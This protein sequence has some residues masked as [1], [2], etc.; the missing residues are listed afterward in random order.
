MHQVISTQPVTLETSLAG[1]KLAG[2][3]IAAHALGFHVKAAF[4]KNEQREIELQTDDVITPA[5]LATIVL[6]GSLGERDLVGRLETLPRPHEIALCM[7]CA[8]ASGVKLDVA[9]DPRPR[10]WVFDRVEDARVILAGKMPA[11]RRLAHSVAGRADAQLHGYCRRHR[12]VF[13]G[14]IASGGV[15]GVFANCASGGFLFISRRAA[16]FF[17]STKDRMTIANDIH[18]SAPLVDEDG[19]AMRLGIASQTLRGDVAK[20][21]RC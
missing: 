7:E 15:V 21:N 9:D 13:H 17:T 16:F 11:L 14:S 20:G 19:C 2:R 10:A 8:I 5:S 1:R 12:R 6:A 18:K 4:L 3:L